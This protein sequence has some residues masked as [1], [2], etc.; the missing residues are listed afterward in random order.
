MRD[1]SISPYLMRR[2]HGAGPRGKTCED[3][4]HFRFLDEDEDDLDLRAGICEKGKPAHSLHFYVCPEWLVCGL[5]V[6]R[7]RAEHEMLEDLGQLRLFAPSSVI[8][9]PVSVCG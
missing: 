3:C 7:E 9:F 2:E 4:A 8:R 1:W 6:S 5:F